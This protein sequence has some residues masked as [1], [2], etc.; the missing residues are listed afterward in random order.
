M[1]QGGF[2][3]EQLERYARH[4]IL[5]QVGGRGQRRLL[6]S[7]VF[8]VGAGGLG[9]PILLYLAAAGVGTI[10]I[11]DDDVVDRSNLQRQII[12]S[13]DDVGEAKVES[14]RA[15]I[16][17]LNPDVKVN[18]LRQRITRDNAMT[19]LRDAAVVLDGSDNFATRYLINDACWFL[20]K[21]LVSGAMHRFEGQ[22]TVFPM[23]GGA[24]SPCYRC[25]FAEPPPADLVPTCQE[26]G[27]LGVRPG[28]I[29][30]LQA[31]EA[32]KLLLGIGRPLVGR[33]LVYDALEMSFR[34]IKL[35][36]DKGCALNGDH[37]TMKE[38]GTYD[39]ERCT[40]NLPSFPREPA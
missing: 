23:N 20:K 33:L 1:A 11:V 9:S 34:T 8:V 29:G 22:V 25:L 19:L 40:S 17:T 37:P 31:T 24:D 7:R 6:D 2:T 32:I 35:H 21:P 10:D 5:P 3:N 18:M 4:I 13:T 28:V 30:S 15:A 39:D 27:I 38:L 12:H 14:A 16:M 36:R 26:A